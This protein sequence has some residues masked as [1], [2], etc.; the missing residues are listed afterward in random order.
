MSEDNIVVYTTTVEMWDDHLY[1]GTADFIVADPIETQTDYMA[2]DYEPTGLIPLPS[3]GKAAYPSRVDGLFVEYYLSLEPT[4]D[5]AQV[6]KLLYE[7]LAFDTFYNGYIAG[8]TGAMPAVSGIVNDYD[9]TTALPID[10]YETLLMETPPFSN[11]LY[12]LT[13]YYIDLESIIY[14]A[15]TDAITPEQGATLIM[16]AVEGAYA[17]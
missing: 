1:N 2:Y 11:D 10:Y 9:Y 12:D 6:I 7:H 16:D 8:V 14:D 17:E 3:G 5:K 15:M 4:S 13:Y